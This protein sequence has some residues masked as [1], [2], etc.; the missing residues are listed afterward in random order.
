MLIDDLIACFHSTSLFLSF[1][2]SLTLSLSHCSRA[3]LPAKPFRSH[4]VIY[5]ILESPPF[6]VFPPP[7]LMQ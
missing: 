3:S 7:L 4:A 2:H 1:S 5:A 6:P